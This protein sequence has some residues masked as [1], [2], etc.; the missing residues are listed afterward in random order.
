MSGANVTAGFGIT[1]KTRDGRSVA[2]ACGPD[3]R[4]L[5]AAGRQ[6]LYPPA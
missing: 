2:F 4:L 5:D 6:D 3:E 1:I